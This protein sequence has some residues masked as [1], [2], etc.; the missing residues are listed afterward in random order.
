MFSNTEKEK[1]YT[2]SSASLL[3]NVYP[4]YLIVN[5]YSAHSQILSSQISDIFPLITFNILRY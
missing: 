1:I 5:L 2:S 4:N 3:K